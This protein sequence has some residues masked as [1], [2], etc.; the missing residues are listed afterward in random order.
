M[1]IFTTAIIAFGIFSAICV[2]AYL[3]SLGEVSYPDVMRWFG[4]MSLAALCWLTAVKLTDKI[5]KNEE[6]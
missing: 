3:L 1:K 2:I 6:D 5:R 4:N